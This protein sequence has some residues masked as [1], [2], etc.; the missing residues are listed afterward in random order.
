MKFQCCFCGTSIC[1]DQ[2]PVELSVGLADAEARQGLYCHGACL[3]NVLHASVPAAFAEAATV[4]VPLLDEGTPVWRPVEAR[5]VAEGCYQIPK[6]VIVPDDET[7]M[8]Q[9]GATLRCH[10]RV[11]QDGT[12]GLVAVAEV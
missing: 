6:S 8:Y 1:G 4:L 7:W 12:V 10:L 9:P 11:F 3:T 5:K 2:R